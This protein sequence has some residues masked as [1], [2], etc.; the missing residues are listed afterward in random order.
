[1]E[2]LKDFIMNSKYLTYLNDPK[3]I[4]TSAALALAAAAYFMKQRR[5]LETFVAKFSCQSLEIP[6]SII[7]NISLFIYIICN[8]LHQ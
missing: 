7:H 3:V 1:M 4:G 8:F 5:E 2:K 6:V